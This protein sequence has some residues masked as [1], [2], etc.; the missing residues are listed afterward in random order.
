MDKKVVTE[1]IQEQCN[2][3]TLFE[4][5]KQISNDPLRASMLEDYKELAQVMG[6]PGASGRTAKL[7]VA[8]LK[9]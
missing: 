3:A 7:I 6:L 9:K 2:T 1:L 8:F 4:T 5:L